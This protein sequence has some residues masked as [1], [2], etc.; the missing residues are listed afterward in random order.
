M[1]VREE[2][3]IDR[4]EFRDWGEVGREWRQLQLAKAIL[5]RLVDSEM[6]DLED[7]SGVEMKEHFDTKIQIEMEERGQF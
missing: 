4:E 6:F 1:G 5:E 2:G 7:L 3:G